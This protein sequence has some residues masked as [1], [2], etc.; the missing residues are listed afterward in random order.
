MLAITQ[1][2]ELALNT[3]TFQEVNNQEVAQ[4]LK[5][6]DGRK[7]TGEDKI[8]PKLVSLAANELTNILTMAVNCSIRNSRF[9]NDAKKA[10]V[11]PLDKGEPNRTVERNF[12]PVSVLNTFSKI[13]EKVLKQQLI[14]HLDNTLSVFIAAYRRA[15]GTQHV[16][17]RL[18]EDW[19]SKLDNDYLVGAI[20][21]DLSKAFDC[22]PHDLLIAKLYAHGLDEDA[23]VLI[24]SYLKRRKQCVRINNTYS[25]FQEVISGVP[26][27]SVL[28][29]ILFNFYINDLFLFIKQA[30]LHNYAD[31]NTLAYFSKNMTDLVY[32]LE[33]ETGV[34]LSWLENNEMIAN[35]EKFHAIL[36]RKNRTNTSGEQININGKM[37]KSEQTVKLLGVTLDYKLD[38]DPHISNLCKKAATQLNVLKRLKTFIGFK[39]KQIL[40]QSFVYSNCNYCPLVWYFSS[41][42][43]LQ[44][45]EQIQ[46]RAL[47]FL[48]NDHTSSYNDLLLKSNKCTMLIARQRILCIEIFKTVKQLNPPFMK[49]IFKL[50]SSHYSA[51]NSNNLAHVRPNQ[52]A[53]GSNSLMSIGPQ[54]WNGLPN[55]IK[56]AEN[57]NSFKVLIK[58]WN[59]PICKCSACKFLPP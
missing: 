47:R 18:V 58:Q 40:V 56:L 53:F 16:L 26:Q 14:K 34:A 4:L 42:K 3:F 41:S 8:P 35:P 31:D 49:D 29:P 36:L 39:E 51:R 10:A 33:K 48:Y 11:C 50:R 25:S 22:I 43:S 6:L 2:P 54:I 57:L 12:R 37:I 20:L 45:I 28:G 15:Y 52:T 1:N 19:R 30:T 32:T 24:Y 13:Y 44:K 59:G 9:P 55:E 46:E 27:G 23:L 7:S 5:S 21:M 38:F 17:I